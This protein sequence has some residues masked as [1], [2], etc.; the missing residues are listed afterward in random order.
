MY[1][2]KERKRQRLARM[3][4][5]LEYG[6]VDNTQEETNQTSADETIA[7]LSE[8]EKV[9]E[10]KKKVRATFVT[11]PIQHLSVVLI[12]CYS[13]QFS[14]RELSCCLQFCC[15]NFSWK[16]TFKKSVG[17]LLYTNYNYIIE[18]KIHVGCSDVVLS[19]GI[20]AIIFL[21]PL[22][23]HHLPSLCSLP[24]AAIK[25][26]PQC[27]KHKEF[28]VPFCIKTHHMGT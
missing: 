5:D 15:C 19:S 14:K 6:S 12:R 7:R 23:H 9:Y 21:A 16:I 2:M 1:R 26:L 22:S 13:H 11:N 10:E 18:N 3:E 8:L 4:S 27:E 25:N 17:E 20:S 28:T 24:I